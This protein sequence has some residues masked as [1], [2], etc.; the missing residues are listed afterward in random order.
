MSQWFFYLA[1]WRTKIISAKLSIAMRPS[2]I[3]GCRLLK[4]QWITNATYR[5]NLDMLFKLTKNRFYSLEVRRYLANWGHILRNM[6][7]LIIL[8][9]CRNVR[10]EAE[11]DNKFAGLQCIEE[12]N[13]KFKLRFTTLRDYLRFP[14]KLTG[15]F[16]QGSLSAEHLSELVF[17]SAEAVG[18]CVQYF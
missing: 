5:N 2:W 10:T 7:A 4:S 15:D 13:F 1:E 6:K 12:I 18:W 11:T 9:F 3:N 17:P 16:Q 14:C 8:F